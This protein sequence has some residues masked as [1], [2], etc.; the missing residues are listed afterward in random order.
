MDS[1]TVKVS[2]LYEQ[3][4]LMKDD[5]MDFVEIKMLEADEDNPEIPASISLTARKE[6]DLYDIDYEDVYSV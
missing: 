6:T 4:K 3:I 5:G 1:I 2:E